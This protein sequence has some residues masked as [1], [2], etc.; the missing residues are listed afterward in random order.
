MWFDCG[1]RNAK[2]NFKPALSTIFRRS[3][4]TDG[5]QFT[6]DV[7]IKKIVYSKPGRGRGWRHRRPRMGIRMRQLLLLLAHF[8]VLALTASGVWA[9]EAPPHKK[10][11]CAW[12]LAAHYSKQEIA[13][14]DPSDASALQDLLQRIYAE[15]ER[16]LGAQDRWWYRPETRNAVNE[17]R[18]AGRAREPE[19]LD[20]NQRKGGSGRRPELPVLILASMFT[21][22]GPQATHVRPESGVRPQLTKRLRRAATLKAT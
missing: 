6:R 20:G 4:Q 9:A 2:N 5:D 21:N 22:P 19:S 14:L 10:A 15:P 16:K 12:A 3:H 13:S 18:S 11:S 1:S 8:A 7:R 17:V